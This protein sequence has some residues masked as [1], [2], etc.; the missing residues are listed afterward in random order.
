MNE[1][2]CP[3][4]DTSLLDIDVFC[5][6][7]GNKVADITKA[8]PTKDKQGFLFKLSALLFVFGAVL[9]SIAY[10]INITS[11]IMILIIIAYVLMILAL[12]IGIY[13]AIKSYKLGK[14]KIGKY[15]VII[16]IIILILILVLSLLPVIL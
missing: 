15:S 1:M 7:C 3:K 16:V 13:N 6:N 8:K 2:K 11:P 14:D 9:I 10:A 4:C 5:P 12:I